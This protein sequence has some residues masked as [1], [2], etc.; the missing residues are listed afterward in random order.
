MAKQ[1]LEER[2]DQR[3]K[4]KLLKGRVQIGTKTVREC[5]KVEGEKGSRRKLKKQSLLELICRREEQES[6]KCRSS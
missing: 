2:E 6:R 5:L 4:E 3:R 1:R